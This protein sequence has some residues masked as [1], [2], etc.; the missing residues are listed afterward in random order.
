MSYRRPL[1]LA[2]LSLLATLLAACAPSLG[3]LGVDLKDS[4]SEC[5]KLTPRRNAP[6]ITEE[7]DYR[8]LSAGALGELNKSNKGITRRNSCDDRI[9]DDYAKAT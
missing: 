5:R 2:I 7:S 8:E 1:L 6:N 9:I 3:N 4:L